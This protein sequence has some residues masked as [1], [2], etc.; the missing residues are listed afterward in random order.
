MQIAILLFFTALLNISSATAQDQILVTAVSDSTRK[1]IL[2]SESISDITESTVL[3]RNQSRSESRRL[4]RSELL[5]GGTEILGMAI[6][7]ALPKRITKWEPG[8]V[9]KAS[10]NLKEA[11]TLPPVWDKDD[12][13]MNYIGHPIAGSYY[14]NASRSQG[15]SKFTSF[16]FSTAQSIIWEY[17]I[18]GV[19][20]RPSIQDLLITSTA[21][22]LLGEAIHKST[23]RMGANGFSSIEKAVVLIINPLFILN[24]KF[25]F[26]GKPSSNFR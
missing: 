15:S 17:C 11:W 16:L 9:K 3:L 20:E 10:S 2:Y 4:W 21:G 5:I 24:N 8:F 26:K 12:F 23:L 22:S 1:Q 19:A 14:Y 25:S 13:A 6:L 18:E 7:M